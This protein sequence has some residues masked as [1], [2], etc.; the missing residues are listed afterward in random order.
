MQN[1]S[2]M[3]QNP[4][5]ESSVFFDKVF[6]QEFKQ[7]LAMLKRTNSSAF[8]LSALKLTQADMGNELLFFC[9]VK[10]I[11]DLS[12]FHE[13]QGKTSFVTS[14]KEITGKGGYAFSNKAKTLKPPAGYRTVAVTE[15]I[16]V[17]N[18]YKSPDDSIR[19]AGIERLESGM[20]VQ[21]F[22]VSEHSI[23][24]KPTYVVTV[25]SKKVANH[26]GGRSI[27]LTNGYSLE[28]V[29]QDR[30]RMR[31]T[32][33]KNIYFITPDYD[34]CMAHVAQIHEYLVYNGFAFNYSLYNVKEEVNGLISEYNLTYR[35][36]EATMDLLDDMV[37]LSLADE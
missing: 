3:M 8:N 35:V 2:M 19:Y 32:E 7:T 31:N 11:S 9:D 6:A 12:L 28:V 27:I 37:S 1:T 17:P 13:V 18:G 21:Y 23:Y 16:Q 20:A 36:L 34:K 26:L 10:G 14:R 33:T 30:S 4:V 22:W 29:V 15:L 25:S 24:R 5:P